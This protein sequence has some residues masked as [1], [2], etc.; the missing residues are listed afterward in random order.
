MKDSTPLQ[1]ANH[2]NVKSR[3]E[4]PKSSDT[5]EAIKQRFVTSPLNNF[6]PLEVEGIGA[7]VA[8]M[9]ASMARLIP[10]FSASRTVREYF[11]K[12]SLPAAVAYR[13]RSENKGAFGP[14]IVRWHGTIDQ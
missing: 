1:A 10:R 7:L 9:R 4:S 8:R 13:S 12:Y 11:T 3:T 5:L 2:N 6:L 14:Q